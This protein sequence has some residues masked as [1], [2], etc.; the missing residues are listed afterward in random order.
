[1]CVCVCVCVC[2]FVCMC[3][4]VYMLVCVC[5]WC[6]LNVCMKCTCA[7][8][9]CAC[10]YVY[11]C[12]FMH[13]RVSCKHT[14]KVVAPTRHA[15]LITCGRSAAVR[16]SARCAGARASTSSATDTNRFSAALKWEGFLLA[17]TE[18]LEA[19]AMKSSDDVSCGRKTRK[20]VERNKAPLFSS[21]APRNTKRLPNTLHI[22]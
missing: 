16:A 21:R 6:V 14:H 3:V 15:P 12:A 22:D 7:C 9:Y 17:L 10:V 4:C 20:R 19:S 13:A 2:A 8:V 1:V 5:M 18:R 11:V